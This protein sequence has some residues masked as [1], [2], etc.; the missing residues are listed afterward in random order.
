MKKFGIKPP[1]RKSKNNF[2]TKSIKSRIY[3]NLIKNLDIS[4]QHQVWVS[5]TSEFKFHGTKWYV[6]TV[7]DITT[8]VVL[9]F[10]I[11]KNHNS[12]LVNK[13]LQMALITSK[14]TPDIFHT[15]QGKEFMAKMN[16]EFLENLNIQISSSDKA[17]PWQNGYQES[18]FGRF[19]EEFGDI[20]RF[21]TIGEMLEEIYHQIYYYNNKRIHTKLK[22]PPILYAKSL[23]LLS[24]KLDT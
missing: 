17:S 6:V 14:T 11:G 8:R 13:A 19:K 15:D 18:F 20:N 4:Y 21:E 9:G 2:C 23:R 22:M 3:P 12:T 16:T 24:D 7:I 5:D 1:R 10:S